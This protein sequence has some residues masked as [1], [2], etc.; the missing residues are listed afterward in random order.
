L[1]ITFINEIDGDKDVWQF[2]DGLSQYLTEQLVEEITLP[3]QPFVFNYD[4]KKGERAGLSFAICW[5]SEG[6][7]PVQ[8]SYVNLIPTAQG[9]T[10]V[11]GLRTGITDALK[12]FCELHNLLPRNVKLAPE[13]VWD[14]VNY[15]LSLKFSEPQFSGQTKERLSS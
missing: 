15:I 1:T 6:G 11:N 9:G 3:E 8:E 4:A 14:G 2:T 5:L 10:H 7:T 12:E 13:D